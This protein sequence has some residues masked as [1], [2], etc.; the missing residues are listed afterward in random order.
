[1]TIFSGK[2]STDCPSYILS[3]KIYKITPLDT[4]N[5]LFVRIKDLGDYIYDA[6]VH[7]ANNTCNK[8]FW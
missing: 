5:Q 4:S 1:M 8:I 3:I 7:V 2:E 6:L